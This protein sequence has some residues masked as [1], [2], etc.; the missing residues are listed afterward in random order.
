MK[1]LIWIST[2]IMLVLA[3]CSEESDEIII[4]MD[5]PDPVVVVEG[6]LTGTVTGKEEGEN[7]PGIHVDLL[8][9]GQVLATVLT[10]DQ[11]SYTF[12]DQFFGEEST[13]VRVHAPSHAPVY[14]P[15]NLEEGESQQQSF[16]IDKVD[17]IDIYAE[18]AFTL[19]TDKGISVEFFEESLNTRFKN[20]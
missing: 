7:L 8:L 2:A 13:V 12:D 1:Q 6:N 5:I 16:L 17:E 19:K 11:G 18:E 4:D 9:E 3:S 14:R 15:V 10:D 20:R